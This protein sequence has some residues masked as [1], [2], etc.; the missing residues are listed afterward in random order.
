[1]HESSPTPNFFER[2]WDGFA[3]RA[4]GAHAR[5]WL[6]FLSFSESSFFVIPPEILLLPMIAARPDKWLSLGLLTSATSVLGAVFGYAIAFFFFDA[7]GVRIIEL[8]HLEEPFAYVG[9]LFERNNFWVMFTAAFTPLPYKV[10][11]LAGGFFKISFVEFLVASI[12]GRTLRYL[13]ISYGA[14]VFGPHATKLALRY[15]G[16]STVIAVILV[17]AVVLWKFVL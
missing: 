2:I 7:F 13:I 3:E 17:G 12:I 15:A 10:A 11:V 5:G 1:M 14:A 8:Y 9:E 6:A 4:Y 16:I